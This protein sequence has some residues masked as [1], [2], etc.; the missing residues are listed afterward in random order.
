MSARTPVTIVGGGP[1]GLACALALR[2]AGRPARLLEAAP[3]LGG[4]VQSRQLGDWLV[5]K[6]PAAILDNS[7]VTHEI[8]KLLDLSGDVVRGAAAVKRRYLVHD[9]K[10]VAL[11]SAPPGIVTSPLLSWRG[12]LRLLGDLLQRP[13][14]RPDESMASFFRRHVGPEATATL[15]DAMQ[16]GIFA[17]DL[18][19]LSAHACFPLLR[20]LEAKHGSLLR[21]VLAGPRQPRPSLMTLRGGLG[22]FINALRAAV[23]D[24]I[25]LDQ[26]IDRVPTS[27]GPIVLAVPASRAAAIVA[28]RDPELAALLRVTTAVPMAAVALGFRRDRIA[29]PLDGFGFLGGPGILGTIFMSSLFPDAGYA[30]A[31]HVQLRVLLGGAHAP[32][33]VQLDERAL[34]DRALAAVLPLVE[35]R[36]DPAFVDVVRWPAGIEQYAVGHLDRLAT[37][38]ARGARLGLHFIGSSF[39]GP[40][41]NDALRQGWELGAQL[42]RA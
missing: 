22:R 7:P 35:G 32:D 36:G 9:G 25:E 30:P 28:E 26:P 13:G 2:L 34:Q 18:E 5:E 24:G 42:G 29:H 33:V 31:E 19:K 6:G 4:R 41:L 20:E 11:P 1:A 27:D 37:I 39:R 8:V 17:G 3:Q 16:S 21:G 23:G 15:V 14:A 38:E 12:K 40:G 10:L